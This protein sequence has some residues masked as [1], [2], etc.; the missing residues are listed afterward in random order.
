VSRLRI[1]IAGVTHWHAPRYL[2]SLAA[3]DTE[4]VGVSDHD[5][6]AGARH[7]E[8]IGCRFFADTSDMLGAARPDFVLLLPRHDLAVREARAIADRRLPTLVE[9]P[10][11]LDAGE[12]RRTAAALLAGNAFAAACLPNRHLLFWD[13]IERLRNDG[14]LGTPIHASFRIVNGPPARYPGYGVPWMLDPA[15]AGGGVLRNLGAHG[16]DASLALGGADLAVRGAV[17]ARRGYGMAIEDYATATL[18]A[19]DG[20]AATIEVGYSHADANSSDQE[21][22]LAATGAYIVDANGALTVTTGDGRRE[23]VKSRTATDGYDMLVAET[24]ARFRSG[25]EPVVDVAQCARAV[26]IIDAIYH[27]AR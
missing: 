27:A 15:R 6:S 3:H 2:E 10:M 12:A 16:A 20:F 5:E 24:L 26:T 19:P 13:A 25:K 4:I 9:K 11:G 8:K 21:F 23:V 14:K 18:A 17:I 22:R 1:A 7:A